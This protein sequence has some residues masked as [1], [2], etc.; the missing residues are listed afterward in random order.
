[1]LQFT[2]IISGYLWLVHSNA[3]GCF[4]AKRMTR[5][6]M[7]KITADFCQWLWKNTLLERREINWMRYQ[8]WCNFSSVYNV[9]HIDHR[10]FSPDHWGCQL[11]DYRT[12]LPILELSTA[13]KVACLSVYSVAPKGYHQCTLPKLA[14]ISLSLGSVETQSVVHIRRVYSRFKCIIHPKGLQIHAGH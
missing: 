5:T 1:M 4:R 8:W 2:H 13:Y 10:P 3:Y 7:N 6:N 9:V 14:L 12:L 11:M